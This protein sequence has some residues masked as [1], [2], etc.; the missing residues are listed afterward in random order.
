M[1][2]DK[3]EKFI[4][5]NKGAEKIFGYTEDEIV[6]KNSSYLFPEG[7]KYIKELSRL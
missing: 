1:M 4:A 3:N 7:D 5:W 6:G 2:V